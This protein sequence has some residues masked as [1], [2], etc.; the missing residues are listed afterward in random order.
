MKIDTL[1]GI[2]NYTLVVYSYDKGF[3]QF[4]IIDRYGVM[5]NFDSI[6]SNS[7]DAYESGK[8]AVNL[9]FEFDLNKHQ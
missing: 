6:F 1:V 8:N 4:C 2:A 7:K 9:A 5:Y 3:Y